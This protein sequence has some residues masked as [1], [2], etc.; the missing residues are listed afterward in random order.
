LGTAEELATGQRPGAGDFEGGKSGA[1]AVH[2]N[3]GF[4]F[5]EKQ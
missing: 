4:T 2:S 3:L 1:V 5:Q